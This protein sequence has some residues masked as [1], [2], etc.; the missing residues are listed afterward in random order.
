[1]TAATDLVTRIGHGDKGAEAEMVQRYGKG[2]L[3]VLRRNAG[4]AELAEDLWQETFRVAIEKLRNSELKEPSRLAGYLK[5]I[6]AN[7]LT[8]DV[9]KSLR[10]RTTAQSDMLDRIADPGGDPLVAASREEVRVAVRQLL[11]EMP[12]ER[13]R[14]ILLRYYVYDEDKRQICDELKLDSVHF[15]RV[16]FRAKQRFHD[17]LIKT[18]NVKHLGVIE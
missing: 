5:G 8:A 18:Q 10:R 7:L 6:A 2:L 15:N 17:L 13:D 11:S 9:R 16:L 1:M 3:Y 14:Q 12:V 4:Q